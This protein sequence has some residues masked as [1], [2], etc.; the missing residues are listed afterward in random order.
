MILVGI[1]A[2]IILTHTTATSRSNSFGIDKP[3]AKL[4]LTTIILEQKSC[5]PDHLGLTLRLTLRNVGQTPVIL[6]K[7][8]AIS[9][10]IV[11]A[12]LPAATNKRYEQDLRY[13]D[14][15]TT[16]GFDLPLLADFR[17]LKPGELIEFEEPVSVYLFN[18]KRRAEQFL[19]EGSHLL[20]VDVGT[21][22]YIANPISFRRKWQD[23]G[24][25]WFEGTTSEPMW[26]TIKKDRPLTKCT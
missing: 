6:S 5:S 20:Q 13:D 22:P 18:E 25:L 12:D 15:G 4:Q 19:S 2:A 26:F 14:P 24:Y 9:R 7:Q 3:T 11:S 1:C 8:T 23:K 10:I 17:I 16:S 21:W